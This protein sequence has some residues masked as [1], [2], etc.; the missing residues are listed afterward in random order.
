MADPNPV[1][2]PDLL[3]LQT[4]Y[5]CGVAYMADPALMPGLIEKTQAPPGNAVWRCAL[6]RP[7]R[8]SS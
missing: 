1:T 6:P 3:T 5:L 7:P 2:L 8:R 4:L